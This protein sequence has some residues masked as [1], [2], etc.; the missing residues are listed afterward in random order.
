MANA[1]WPPRAALITGAAGG[2]GRQLTLMLAQSG[3]TVGAID[4]NAAGLQS[5]RQEMSAFGAMCSFETADVTNAESLGHTVDS[6]GAQV[7]P[8]DLLI[9]CAGIGIETPASTLDPALFAR[10]INVNLIGVSNS[11]AA[12]LP[13]MLTRGRGHLAAISSLA[14]YRGLPLMAAYCA[15]KS[16]VNALM[17]AIRIE[18]EPRGI[19]T[20]IIC[21]GWVR[22]PMIAHLTVPMPDML[23]VGDAARRILTAICKGKRFVAFPARTAWR[24]RV[25]RMFPAG[26]SD[27]AVRR[28]MASMKRG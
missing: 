25:L 11:F 4:M 13:G 7:G 28:F 15:S 24:L 18:A 14:S 10:I 6:V 23:E 16:G 12:V 19:K 17:E 27:W 20:T 26:V 9:A 21:P 2:L 8:I 1:S 5:L 22:T 3:V